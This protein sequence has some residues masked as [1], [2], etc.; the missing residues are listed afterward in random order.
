MG[1]WLEFELE[2]DIRAWR[3]SKLLL[4]RDSRA[5]FDSIRKLAEA[6]SLLAML[7]L[8]RAYALGIGTTRNDAEAE[9]W[10]ATVAATRSVHGHYYLGRFFLRTK[11]YREAR[12]AMEFSAARGYGPALHDLGKIYLRGLGVARNEQT[13]MRYLQRAVEA[14]SIFAKRRLGGLTMQSATDVK[15]RLKGIVIIGH[16]FLDMVRT[17]VRSGPDSERLLP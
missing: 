1:N 3:E 5:G 9:K 7:E 15:T 4:K 12:E 13:G 17:L 16:A 6:G 14:G 2:P 10:L 11:K 8:G